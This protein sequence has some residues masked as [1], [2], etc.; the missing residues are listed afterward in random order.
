MKAR[1]NTH[2]KGSMDAISSQM[3]K[4]I[5]DKIS[6]NP[7][8]PDFEVAKEKKKV[9]LLYDPSKI[10]IE[11]NIPIPN[12][13]KPPGMHGGMR[14]RYPYERMEVGDSYFVELI[15]PPLPTVKDWKFISRR[16]HENG[17]YGTRVWRVK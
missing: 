3:V 10:K 4:E 11:K 1:R 2:I 15:N 17:V 8:E 5:L 7:K 6:P 12:P 13:I 9:R 14:R 16:L